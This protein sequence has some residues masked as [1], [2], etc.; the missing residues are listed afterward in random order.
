MPRFGKSKRFV[1][2]SAPRA[3]PVLRSGGLAAALAL[4]GVLAFAAVLAFDLATALALAG[5][6]TLAG[7]LRGCRSS[8]SCCGGGGAP[9]PPPPAGVRRGAVA[10][11]RPLPP[12]PP[13]FHR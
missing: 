10:T 2:R 5:V 4:A 3:E 7:V 9:P 8:G 12:Q 11:P 1:T 13:V 6:L